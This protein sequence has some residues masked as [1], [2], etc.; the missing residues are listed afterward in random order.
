MKDLVRET[1]RTM[2]MSHI[3]GR[4]KLSYEYNL[5]ALLAS[6]A[7]LI[8]AGVEERVLEALLNQ[9]AMW[10][11]DK[12]PGLRDTPK[13]C[14]AGCDRCDV[15][16]DG[17]TNGYVNGATN[18][19]VP[20]LEDTYTFE[21]WYLKGCPGRYALDEDFDFDPGATHVYLKDV[22]AATLDD[23][24]RKMQGSFWSPNGEANDLIRSKGLG[25]TSMSIGDVLRFKDRGL[26]K[27]AFVCMPNFVKF[28]NLDHYA[29]WE[30][31]SRVKEL[32]REGALP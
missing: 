2:L 11:N 32:I 3:L 16:V 10:A 5:G 24:Y 23:A 26:P 27:T 20:P 4:F 9:A 22:E 15:W 19:P 25:H 17:I 28:E 29:P 13:A 1:L 12:C 7:V 21:V 8:R 30:P 18:Y 14:R 6:K 31:V